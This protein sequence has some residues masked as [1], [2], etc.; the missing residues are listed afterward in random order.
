M[1][2]LAIKGTGIR[3]RAELRGSGEGTIKAGSA[4][5]HRKAGIKERLQRISLFVQDLMSGPAVEA[6]L[7]A[8]DD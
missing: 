5:V 1:G 2:R 6:D 3:D 4:A 8:D 7:Q